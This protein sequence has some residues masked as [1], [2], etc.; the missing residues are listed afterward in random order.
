VLAPTAQAMQLTFAT[1]G[2]AAAPVPSSA[3]A[4]PAAPAAPVSTPVSGKRLSKFGRCY[5]YL[6]L[7]VVSGR[8]F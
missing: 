4:T 6:N 1:T 8:V 3:G 2:P 7:R 5:V